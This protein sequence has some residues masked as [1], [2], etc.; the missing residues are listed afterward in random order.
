LI[1]RVPLVWKTDWGLAP[2]LP[3][4]MLRI[5]NGDKFIL[6]RSDAVGVE[7]IGLKGIHISTD[8]HGAVFPRFRVSD[9][10]SDIP[11][12]K[13]MAGEIGEEDIKDRMILIG[14]TATGLASVVQTSKGA[15]YSVDF[16]RQILDNILS[17]RLLWRPS[18]AIAIELIMTALSAGALALLLLN[19]DLVSF[20]VVAFGMEGLILA[21]GEFAYRQYS[22]LID[23]SYPI[24]ILLI[25]SLVF[26]VF[27]Y[28]A[29]AANRRRASL[30]MKRSSTHRAA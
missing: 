23:V 4:E 25:I 29:I 18:F 13:L 30:E 26:L 5:F 7:Q 21:I 6:I 20:L 9:R 19:R 16:Y 3:L 15:L 22:M 14:A 11:V 12:W 2:S 17:G 8:E 27:L 1:R 28:V 10:Q 24:A